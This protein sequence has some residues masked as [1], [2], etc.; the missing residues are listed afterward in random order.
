VPL[1]APQVPS[2]NLINLKGGGWLS[3]GTLVNFGGNDAENGIPS[4]NGYQG[5]RLFTPQP[6]GG[7]EV[8]EDIANVH[9]A[10]NR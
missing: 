10:V 8:F 9:L 2:D 1:P 6:G 3:N 4:G 5:L 7:G